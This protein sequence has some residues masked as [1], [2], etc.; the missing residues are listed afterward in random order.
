MKTTHSFRFSALLVSATLL[1]GCM[2]TKPDEAKYSGWMKDYSNLTEFKTPTGAT[3]M[4]WISPEL[5]KGQYSA[6][7][8][9]PVTYYPEP[10]TA[11]QVSMK[12][13]NEIPEY[14]AQRVSQEVGKTMPVVQKPGPGVLRMRAAIT[15]V[16]TP[17]EGLK[18]YEV[19]PIAL[20]FAGASTAAGTRDHNT[21]VYMEAVMTDS[22]SG[23]IL[24]K[25]VRKGI[26]QPLENNKSQLTVADT[27]P[28]IDGW[29]KD[30]AVFVSTS[31][32]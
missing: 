3:S 24:G 12:T 4:R 16:E 15:A 18:A 26:G 29:A 28:V 14:L 20:I 32:K 19:I 25:V 17:T 9:D 13:L 21:I 30:A 10:K 31:V 6:I 7:M 11:Q 27:K 23:K 5:Q 8:I 1:A 2:T 22:Q